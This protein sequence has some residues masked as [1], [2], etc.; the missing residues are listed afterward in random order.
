[1]SPSVAFCCARPRPL[2]TP[3]TY[4]LPKSGASKLHGLGLA[5]SGP[6][7]VGIVIAFEAGVSGAGAG[8]SAPAGGG[9]GGCCAEAGSVIPNAAVVAKIAT[10]TP[11]VVEL[12]DIP[13]SPGKSCLTHYALNF[14][15][16]VRRARD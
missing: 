13:H 1:M 3:V 8:A 15:I 10:L 14:L 4:I 12:L 11:L 9:G 7:M 2:A 6:V 16:S 5:T